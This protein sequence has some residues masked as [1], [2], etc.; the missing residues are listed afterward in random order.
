M[1]WDPYLTQYFLEG[2]N[3]SNSNSGTQLQDRKKKLR[4]VSQRDLNVN[5]TLLLLKHRQYLTS[6]ISSVLSMK[7]V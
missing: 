2:S 7:C 5:L 6:G 3:I 4:F 1:D